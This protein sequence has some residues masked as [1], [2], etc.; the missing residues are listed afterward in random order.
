[1]RK[2]TVGVIG[3][4]MGR[5]HVAAYAANPHCELRALADVDPGRLQEFGDNY[6]V[7][8]R[9]REGSELIARETLDA[10]SIATPNAYHA[11]LTLEALAR[12][13]H[14]FTEKPMAMNLTEAR[15]M[16]EAAVRA[17]RKLMVNFSYRF[18]PMSFALKR[19]IDAGIVGPIYFGRTVW[20]RRRG[21]PG[22]G[23]WFG[24]RDLAG[25]GPLIDLGVHRID[26]ALWLMGHPEPVS[27]SGSTYDCIGRVEAEKAGKSFTVEDLACGLVKFA[28]GATLIVETSWALQINEAERMVTELYGPR[29]GIVQRNTGGGYGMHAELHLEEDGNFFTKRLD[30]TSARPPKPYDE[31]VA[32]ILEDR[33]P[34]ADAEEGVKVQKIIDG[35][36]RSA[37]EGRETRFD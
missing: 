17:E 7:K 24:R 1:M 23:G 13:A 37:A 28:N 6:A 30:H 21:F 3:L 5:N 31:F 9:Y 18:S 33:P 14:V 35:L 8:N 27:V 32:C 34:M 19:Q 25:G 2:L 20:H 29:G 12:G 11:P 10:V 4:G 22:F 26:L 36:Y 16:C 15:S